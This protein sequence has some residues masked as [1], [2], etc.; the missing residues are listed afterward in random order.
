GRCSPLLRHVKCMRNEPTAMGVPHLT[1]VQSNTHSDST[2]LLHPP[3]IA[4][5]GC[6]IRIRRCA[7]HP[8]RTLPNLVQ[9]HPA[10]PA[11]P[12]R[13]RGD[14]RAAPAPA[15]RCAC[16]VDGMGRRREMRDAV[17]LLQRSPIPVC[18]YRGACL[19]APDESL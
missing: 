3:D 7:D 14:V 13:C 8:L 19:A 6:E 4:A 12:G 2:A 11:S 1:S 15:N 16:R 5:A 17:L 10:T 18:G 9:R